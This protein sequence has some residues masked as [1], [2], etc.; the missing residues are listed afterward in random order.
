MDRRVV[1]ALQAQAGIADWTLRVERSRGV[2]IYLVGTDVESVR[3]VSRE[4]YE[5]DL[6]H[7]HPAPAESGIDGGKARGSA[8]IPLALID[9]DRL[10]AV[11]DDAVT[12]ASL[13]NNPPW[14]L[15][16]TASQPEIPLSDPRLV[17]SGEA[18]R[19]GLE[20]ADEIREL[21]T[22]EAARGVRLSGAELFLTHYEEELV[23][24][25]GVAVTA[26][27]TRIL[28]EITLLARGA[29]DETEYFRQTEG[30]RL[31]DL[32]LGEV[33]PIGAELA[34]DKLRASAPRTHQ[35]PVLIS[36]E[37][38]N[39]MMIG[40]VT[41]APGAYLFQAAARTAYEHL[42]RF[43]LGGSV[44]AGAEPAGDLLTLRANALRPYGVDS[45]R[46]DSDGVPASNLLV[47]DG[48]VLLARPATQRYAQYLGLPATGRPGVAEIEPGA[49][50]IHDLRTAD[51][52]I[53]EVLDFSASNVESLSGD[54]G[55][56]IRVGYR[57][58]PDG[59]T[60]ISGGSVTGNLFE[61]MANARFSSEEA[62]FG[63]YAGPIGIRFESLQVAGQD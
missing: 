34:R 7:D 32:N 56:E 60:P 44:Y 26:T 20:A 41:G 38:L 40:Q 42:S 22:A 4:A 13:I 39:Q 35:G 11:L 43:E 51:G 6:F 27:A 21:A 9:L 14:S 48:G 2:Q 37:A 46:W 17:D 19:A 12:M 52:P 8:T 62:D 36:G 25:R 50:T 24:S 15:P 1:D 59:R 33:I 18:M 3:Q 28:M 16:E 47:I 58:G 54:F 29:Q 55:M 49:T 45:Y 23:N 63:R 57:W 31:A 5:I 61:A 10:P 30:R 53:L